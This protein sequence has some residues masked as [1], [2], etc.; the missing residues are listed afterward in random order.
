MEHRCSL[1]KPIE[2]QLLLYKH[3]LPVKIGICRNLGLGGLF[4]ETGRYEWREMEALQV[5][6]VGYNGKP[7]MR[8]PAV[9]IHHSERGAGLMF[10]AVSS[11][12]RRVLCGWLFGGRN[13]RP[14]G[15]DALQQ[16]SCRAVA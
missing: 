14:T 4:V 12:Q 7:S 2:L 13:Q 3:G 9:L 1:R 6:L 5:E 16:G 8:L 11:E 15:S 10:D